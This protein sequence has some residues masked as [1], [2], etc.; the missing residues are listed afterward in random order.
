M[1]SKGVSW[2]V[3]PCLCCAESVPISRVN[4]GYGQIHKHI[5]SPELA[6]DHSPFADPCA[7]PQ[8][9]LDEG[10]QQSACFAD[11]ELL[12]RNSAHGY[13]ELRKGPHALAAVHRMK[14]MQIGKR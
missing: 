2:H 12:F 10:R 8:V 1:R 6:I 7:S 14:M 13:V 4:G 9:T 5:R 11:V 3:E